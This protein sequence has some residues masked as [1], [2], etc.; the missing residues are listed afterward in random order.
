MDVVAK[1]YR[2][3]GSTLWTIGVTG[4]GVDLTTQARFVEECEDMAR[5]VV[6][7]TCDI[8]TESVRVELTWSDEE[9]G[10]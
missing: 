4:E 5:E 2:E 7:V 3:P 8:P 10:E 6:A 1:A 9:R